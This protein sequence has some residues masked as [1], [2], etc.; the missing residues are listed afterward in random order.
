MP[1]D[2]SWGSLARFLE[3][4]EIPR[5]TRLRSS[6]PEPCSGRLCTTCSLRGHPTSAAAG[7]G[8]PHPSPV[9]RQPASCC[10]G[11]TT[12]P[13]T[14]QRSGSLLTRSKSSAAYPRR[15]DAAVTFCTRDGSGE[16]V[17]RPWPHRAS[18]G[19]EETL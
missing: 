11:S 9:W 15:G 1:R 14:A 5:M 19:G 8:V 4:M 10:A 6:R 7:Q 2:G 13:A 12:F 3:Y 16:T 17:P 18:P